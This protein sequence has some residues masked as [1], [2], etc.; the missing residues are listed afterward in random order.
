MRVG[1]LELPASWGE[2]ARALDRVD[3]A[4]ARGPAADVILLPEASLTGYVSPQLEFDLTRFAEPIDGPTARRLAEIARARRVH[5]FAPLIEREGARVYN[6]MIGLTPEGE[7][8]TRYRK[9]HPWY[10]EAW[11]TPGDAPF[12]C[13]DLLGRR[14]MIAICFDV[15]FLRAEAAA[16]LREADV[17]LFP[18]AWV[19]ENDERPVL[20]PA[21][22]REAGVAIVNANWGPGVV[23]VPGQ[24]GSAVYR[25]DGDVIAQVQ[26]GVLRADACL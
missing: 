5:L 17:L 12:A 15:H 10:P 25:A 14:A 20:L 26:S 23:R 24:G 19:E 2:P 22:A 3:E 13:F 16:S 4:L 1:I 21:L 8:L 9:R 6:A 7:L 18:S 11:A